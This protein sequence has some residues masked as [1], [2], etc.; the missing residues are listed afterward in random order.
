MERVREMMEMVVAVLSMRWLQ[1]KQRMFRTLTAKRTGMEG[2]VVV[3][4]ICIVAIAIGIV[5]RDAIKTWISTIMAKF[6]TETTNL[7]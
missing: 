1:F 2:F 6:T 5:F 7:F 4:I 3:I